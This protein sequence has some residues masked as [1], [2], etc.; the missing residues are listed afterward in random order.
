[1]LIHKLRVSP[2][3]FASRRSVLTHIVKRLSCVL[4]RTSEVEPQ[5]IKIA[6]ASG[7]RPHCTVKHCCHSV[8]HI[9]QLSGCSVDG[10]QSA[11]TSVN[12]ALQQLAR[13]PHT[14]AL[15]CTDRVISACSCRIA[16]VTSDHSAVETVWMLAW[17][18]F[19]ALLRGQQALQLD[20]DTTVTAKTSG[21]TPLRH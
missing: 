7:R 4:H 15:R 21:E 17:R 19:Y 6:T 8:L 3:P 2:P 18:A 14:G 20:N 10:S 12:P 11:W 16:M 1:M 13:Q 5:Y 9:V